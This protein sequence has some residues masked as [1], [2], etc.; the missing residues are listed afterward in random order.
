MTVSQKANVGAVSVS[1][2]LPA[3]FRLPGT[4]CK[5]NTLSLIVQLNLTLFKYRMINAVGT[6]IPRP[7]ASLGERISFCF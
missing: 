6:I 1:S 4:H 7:V 3:Y 5:F 2:S